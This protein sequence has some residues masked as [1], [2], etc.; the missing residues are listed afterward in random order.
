MISHISLTYTADFLKSMK[1]N[2]ESDESDAARFMINRS[3]GDYKITLIKTRHNEVKI[4]CENESDPTDY[5]IF[6]SGVL[7]SVGDNL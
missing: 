3:E 4:I 2:I 1:H 6:R 7:K 5:C